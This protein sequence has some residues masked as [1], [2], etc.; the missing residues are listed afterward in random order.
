MAII[1]NAIYDRIPA[2]WWSDD[3]FMALLRNAVNST[4]L[5]VLPRNPG[6]ANRSGAIVAACARRG[7]RWRIA[8]RALRRDRLC[9]HWNNREFTEAF[10]RRLRRP[11]VWSAPAW[12]VRA[13]VGK[14]RASI[15]LEGQNIRPK[16][17]LE[18]GYRFRYPE[19]DD[20]MAD[21]V[22]VTF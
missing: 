19:L 5:S 1:D 11:V 21:L 3:S 9:S 16:R 17:T 8:L 14:D 20:A 18:A 10:A 15:L 12:L 7:L 13:V 4:A 6:R 22:L 2:A